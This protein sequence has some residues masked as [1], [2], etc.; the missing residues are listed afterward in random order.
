MPKQ[1]DN[2]PICLTTNQIGKIIKEGELEKL[3]R[4]SGGEYML[5]P[6]TLLITPRDL[7]LITRILLSVPMQSISE[8]VETKYGIARLVHKRAIKYAKEK[9]YKYYTIIGNLGKSQGNF[10]FSING[11]YYFRDDVRGALA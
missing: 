9:G 1:E 11:Y 8:Y 5:Y 10:E 6:T 3:A 4:E 2:I 7:P